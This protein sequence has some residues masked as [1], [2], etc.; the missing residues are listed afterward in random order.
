MPILV[1]DGDGM[2]NAVLEAAAASKERATRLLRVRV[3]GI[4]LRSL[5]WFQQVGLLAMQSGPA[6]IL[7]REREPMT[8]AKTGSNEKKRE[9]EPGNS[10]F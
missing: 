10:V 6:R 1:V 5:L 8:F 2:I 3:E 7:E 9:S 4:I